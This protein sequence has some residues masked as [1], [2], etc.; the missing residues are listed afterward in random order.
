[1]YKIFDPKISF[2]II[3]SKEI[4]QGNIVLQMMHSTILYKNTNCRIIY[5]MKLEAKQMSNKEGLVELQCVHTVELHMLAW[6]SL[7]DLLRSLF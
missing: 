5:N 3:Y 4:Y 6:R 1:M 7:C 2:L